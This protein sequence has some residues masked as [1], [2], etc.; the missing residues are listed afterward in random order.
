MSYD[1]G[2]AG[3]GEAIGNVIGSYRRDRE[4]RQVAA[5]IDARDARIAE[6]ED[7]LQRT[8]VQVQQRNDIISATI[9]IRHALEEQL[10]IYDPTNPLL[11]DRDLRGRVG[12]AGQLAF[13]ATRSV[14]SSREAGVSFVIND[15]RPQDDPA[16]GVPFAEKDLLA[17]R[18]QSYIENYGELHDK[19]RQFQ[20]DRQLIEHDFAAHRAQ[21]AALRAVVEKE[22]PGHPLVTNADLRARISKAGQTAL[23]MAPRARRWEA[24]DEAGASFVREPDGPP[25]AGV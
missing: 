15:T 20:E 23:A 4:V 13:N 17:N 3:L 5:A 25:S 6:L 7:L 18:L 16:R 8:G 10:R 12:A 14:E 9:A 22:L 11:V 2:A 1:P 24:V 21:R 19:A